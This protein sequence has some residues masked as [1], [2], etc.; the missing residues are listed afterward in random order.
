MAGPLTQ[1]S[2]AALKK[3]LSLATDASAACA[4]AIQA[5]VDLGEDKQEC[6]H[7]VA[8]AQQML[9]VYL[10]SSSFKLPSSTPESNG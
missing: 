1:P 8:S 3:A 7:L 5:G 4:K 6:D 9:D 2:I 10:G